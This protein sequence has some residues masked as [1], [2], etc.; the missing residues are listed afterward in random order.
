M[1]I[2]P[3][4]FQ[5]VFQDTYLSYTPTFT[6]FSVDPV[7][8]A[9]YANLGGMVNLWIT[10]SVHGT[11][12]ATSLTFTLPIATANTIS[13]QL[14]SAR[15]TDAGASQSQPGL[16]VLTAN[17]T[18]ATVY[19]TSQASGTSWTASGSKSFKINILYEASG[20]SAYTPSWTGFSAN[21]TVTARYF[22]NGKFVHV[23]MT[24][25]GHGT[26]NATTLTVTLPFTA[27]NTVNQYVPIAGYNNNGSRGAI[28]GLGVIG[29]NTNIMTC[30]INMQSGTWSSSSSKS[31]SCSFEYECI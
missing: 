30:Y 28:A 24:A 13:Q 15:V 27:A 20:Y 12:N 26:S 21:P 25:S 11:S 29:A 14:V 6:G 19:K 18:T 22:Q 8:I 2:N 23:Y 3:Y 5:R 17:S 4:I 7:V 1:I 16:V 31:I 9:H 10:P